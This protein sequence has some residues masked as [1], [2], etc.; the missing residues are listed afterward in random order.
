MKKI[1]PV[2]GFICMLILSI[3]LLVSADAVTSASVISLKIENYPDKTVY[4]AFEQLDKSGLVLSATLSDGS[5][6][7]IMGDEID[8]GY[9]RDGCFRVGDR[10]VRLSYGGQAVDL[11]ITVNRIEYDLS[12]LSLDSISTIY[13]GRFQ[14]YN[15]LLPKIVGLDGIPLRMTALGGSV[16]A[17]TYD[18]SIDFYTRNDYNKYY[19]CKNMEEEYE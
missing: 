6:R 15:E 8:V 16:D 7:R 9:N 11:P 4:G 14:S 12:A 17:G 18:I 19:G 2:L 3:F 13:N 5:T 1:I 10:S